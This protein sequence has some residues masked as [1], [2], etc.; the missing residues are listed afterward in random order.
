MASHAHTGLSTTAR[1]ATFHSPLVS[2]FFD[3]V[4]TFFVNIMLVLV[5]YM[6]VNG[7]VLSLSIDL[8]AGYQASSNMVAQPVDAPTPRTHPS[9]NDRVL[10]YQIGRL[11]K[12]VHGLFTTLVHRDG[13]TPAILVMDLQMGDNHTNSVLRLLPPRVTRHPPATTSLHAPDDGHDDDVISMASNSSNDAD[14]GAA[15]HGHGSGSDG[16]VMYPVPMG[17][18]FFAQFERN[19]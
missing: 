4:E 16:I 15:R 7:T 13:R 6:N 8:G 18:D 1:S 5:D 19:S 3:A 12:L 11:I 2:D 10:R 9:G 17:F 14:L